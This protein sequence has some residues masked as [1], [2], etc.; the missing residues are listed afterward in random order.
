MG[1]HK[2]FQLLYLCSSWKWNKT[3]TGNSEHNNSDS[4]LTQGLMTAKAYALAIGYLNTPQTFL[5]GE[6]NNSLGS[7]KIR[8]NLTMCKFRP[9]YY[10]T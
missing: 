6:D 2:N 1:L 7:E 3:S 10:Q 8:E 5:N 9:H 4:A